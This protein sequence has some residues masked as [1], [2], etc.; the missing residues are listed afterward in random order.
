MRWKNLCVALLAICAFC[1]GVP[2]GAAELSADLDMYLSTIPADQKVRVV[3]RVTG[4]TDGI[5]LQR[6]LADSYMRRADRHREA[7]LTLQQT[8]NRTQAAILP[9]LD[10]LQLE[11]RADKVKPYWIDNLIS[12]EVTPSAIRELA[13]RDDIDRIYP[14]PEMKSI[15]P[16]TGGILGKPG[17]GTAEIGL[18]AIGADVMWDA[19]YTGNGVLV[20]HID[21]GIDGDHPALSAK[22]RG[23]NG[24]S[25]AESW[26][27]PTEG[28]ATPHTFGSA[29]E[30]SYFH[31]TATMGLMVGHDPSTGDTTGVAFNAQWIAAA[32]LDLPGAD[33]FEALQW[34]ID[35]DGDPNTEDDVPDVISNSWGYISFPD[36]APLVE[37]DDLFWNVIDNLE[38]ADAITF[39]AAGNEG[40]DGTNLFEQSIRNPANRIASE[41]NAF[42]VGMI[43]AEYYPDSLFFP[44][45][46]SRGPS[47]CDSVTI[48]PEVVAPGWYIRSTMPN[49]TYS[50]GSELLGGTSFAAPHV[51]GAAALLREY[52]PNATVDT[53]KKVLLYSATD[54]NFQQGDQ[55][56]DNK[57]G[58]GLINIP[59]ALAMMPANTE[60]HLYITATSYTRPSPGSTTHITVTVRNSGT[61]VSN[62]TLNMVSLDPRLDTDTDLV[63]LGGFNMG[64][65]KDNAAS[66]FLAIVGGDVSL[67][68]RLPVEWRFTGDGYSRTVRG[69]ITVGAPSELDIF[70]HDVGNVVFTVTSF[71]EYGLASDANVTRLGA[72]GFLH[73][74]TSPTQSL[75]EMGFLVGAGPDH[76][77]DAVRQIGDIPDNDFLVDK[78]G[79]IRVEEPGLYADQQ[80][81]AGY[82]DAQ[83]ENPLGLYIEQRSYAWADTMNDDY[84]ILEYVIHNR[85]DSA[86]SGVRAALFADWDFPWGTSQAASDY[87]RF[88]SSAAVGW[89]MHRRESDRLFRGIAALTPGGMVSY[90]YNNNPAELYDGFT[91]EKKWDYMTAGFDSVRA[92]STIDASHIMTI[93][94]FDLQPG[95][96]AVAAFAVIG[97]EYNNDIALFA[98]RARAKY[99]CML[100]LAS[101]AALV[102]DPDSLGFA[103]EAG[104]TLPPSRTI[105][106][107]N[108]CGT[109]DWQLAH[110]QSWL[111][112]DASSGT[113]PDTVTV[114]ITTIDLAI[115]M[116]RDT[117]QVRTSDDTDTVLVPVSLEIVE[118]L[119]RLRVE[120]NWIHVTFSSAD[121][122]VDVPRVWVCNDGFDTMT[123]SAANAE[124]WLSF[125]PASGTVL[126]GDSAEVVLTL[127]APGFTFVPG[128]YEDAIAVTAPGAY[129][130]PDTV[131]VLLSVNVPSTAVTNAPNPFD[132][133]SEE[134]VISLGL[135]ARSEVEAKIYD[136]AGVLVRVL[137]AA[138]MD[139]GATLSWDGK[140]DDGPYVAD[141]VYLC[142]IKKTTENGDSRENI[143]K[144]AVAK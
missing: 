55:G 47:N 100:G 133:Y 36:W 26:F 18:R 130:T 134:T 63:S 6:T 104:G 35:P 29:S 42:A 87:G 8:A 4:A 31:G 82:S 124:V 137:T 34:L 122:L 98:G 123:W 131:E 66:P 90:R 14:F 27:D 97:A 114:A 110:S 19:G 1:S 75:F 57:T 12:A 140:T 118:G 99:L 109:I 25:S 58:M 80:T 77:S 73:L 112:V 89:M 59:A 144:I 23:N 85:S 81:W 79:K 41:V 10:R 38:A 32:A 5:A 20:G 115:G 53:I 129:D 50:G 15:P 22:W 84:V 107:N 46:S 2:L 92:L 101:E 106:I 76:V 69:A 74:P 48:K 128:E 102:A 68:E 111:S 141:G 142:H 40:H 121:T 13:V 61:P 65:S 127:G 119:P 11:D 33:I 51:A 30:P 37:C 56:N 116:Y 126:P 44:L 143:I 120:P 7:L 132:P 49:G 62:V 64:Q 39:W 88:D 45:Q 86:L 139:P 103:A 91:E 94:E 24:H 138:W 43:M 83:A 113:T 60:P 9:L 3:F 96:S 108:L 136:L 70:T 135:S 28:E 117:V 67:G 95:D 72:Q 52:N 71:G 21:T 105:V 78:S 54:L 17:A 125:I 16:V 93:G